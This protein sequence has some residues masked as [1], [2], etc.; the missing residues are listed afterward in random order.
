MGANV[1]HLV[2]SG[3]FTLDGG[4]FE[5]DN[6]VWIVGDD[7]DVLVIDPAHEPDRVLEAVGGRHLTAIVC[8][9]GHNDH[10]NGAVPLAGKT[11]APVLLHP[12]DHELWHQVHPDRPPDR[13]LADGEVLT[14][15]GTDLEVIHTPGHTWGSI[16]LHVP[17]RG[18]LFSGDTLF[19]GGPGAT[20]RSYSD[21]G[22]I[23]RSI[24]DRLLALDGETIVHT[25][26]GPRT[27]IG[28]ESVNAQ[29]WALP[30]N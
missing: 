18:W 3:S 21:Y 16:C 7:R 19:Q 15:A 28:A 20:G 1:E 4:T 22:A 6:N 27:A 25:G 10:V 17:E 24:S 9:H 2:T 8:T 14:V 23:I 11:G 26:H 13:A 30:E 5:V 29:G 12:D